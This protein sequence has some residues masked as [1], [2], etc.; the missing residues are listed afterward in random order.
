MSDIKEINFIK[1]VERTAKRDA[2][3]TAA[4]YIKHFGLEFGLK[5]IIEKADAHSE[6]LNSLPLVYDYA[7]QSLQPKH[8]AIDGDKADEAMSGLLQELGEDRGDG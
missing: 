1:Q 3:R 4:R 6:Y 2:Y 8:V 7:T 5:T